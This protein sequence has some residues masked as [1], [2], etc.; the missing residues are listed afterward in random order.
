MEDMFTRRQMLVL[1]AAGVS[2]TLLAACSNGSK[3]PSATGA[4][5]KR[6]APGDREPDV[7]AAYLAAPME[8]D[9]AGTVVSTW[10][11][12]EAVPGK[13]L[14]A[15]VGDLVEVTIDNALAEATS[16]H[17]HGIAISND[18]DGVPGVTQSD[19]VAGGSFTY[20]FVVPDSGTYWFHPHHGLQL[21]RGLYAP[22]IV[23]D[24]SE[25]MG[26]DA[27][28]VIVLD[29]WLD[30]LGTTPDD[31]L[32][33]IREMGA[34]M[35]DMDGG[36]DMGDMTMAT[37]PLLG[38]DAGD[39]V[40]PHHLI[41]GRPL[42]DPFT[43][44]PRPNAGDRLR[45]RLINAAG[46][47][48]YRVAIGGHRMTVTHTDGFPIDPVTVDALIIGMGERYD[49]TVD[50]ES[51]AWPII[52]LAEGKDARAAAVLRT[53]DASATAAPE[54]MANVPELDGAW[55]RY[56]DLRTADRTRLAVPESARS[57]ALSLTGGMAKF[58]WGI[59]GRKYGEHV[60][61]EVD[62]G[63]WVTLVIQN[64]TSMWHPIH[65]H[66]H[67]PQLATRAGGIRKDTVNILPRETAQL[68]F[69]ADNRGTWMLHCHNAYHLEAGMA[70]L[71]SYKT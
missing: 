65:L 13:L 57:I 41:N 12:N 1:G 28:H 49:V 23:D 58:D 31:E 21:D 67:T 25:E 38:G 63:E 14:R 71:L 27:D 18:M 2:S 17:W 15:R 55:L 16:I 4:V 35:G 44:D 56:A 9:L 39:A 33:R 53:R 68:A 36:H 50:V 20:R 62:A 29:D 52:A 60:P 61:I 59:D 22:L 10:G 40:Y 69:Q 47:T 66:G 3:E 48:A 51:G 46:D 54:I 37:S 5:S 24:P 45:I 11:Y 43:L 8:L 19:I 7:V 42:G 32:A 64:A 26:V 70:T 34:A 30:G 6:Q